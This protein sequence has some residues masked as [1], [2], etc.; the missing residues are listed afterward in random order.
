MNKLAL[1]VR[2]LLCFADIRTELSMDNP[3]SNQSRKVNFNRCNNW[4]WTSRLDGWLSASHSSCPTSKSGSSS[5][6]QPLKQT[7]NT[8]LLVCL[9]PVSPYQQAAFS[10]YPRPLLSVV[11]SLSY[12]PV[13]LW[14]F[15]KH[16]WLFCYGKPWIDSIIPA[17][18]VV[19]YWWEVDAKMLSIVKPPIYR[20]IYNSA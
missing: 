3:P 18:V 2:S 7:Q 4:S 5:Q 19:I 16:K 11:S 13:W 1:L 20:Q 17:W 15:V 6:V 9:P 12:L 14:I 8:P 10:G